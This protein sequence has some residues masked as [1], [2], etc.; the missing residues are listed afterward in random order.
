[1]SPLY[2]TYRFE[3]PDLLPWVGSRAEAWKALQGELSG[4][5]LPALWGQ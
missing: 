3:C 1:M 4:G 2:E 5:N